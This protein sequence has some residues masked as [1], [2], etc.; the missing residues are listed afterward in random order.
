MHRYYQGKGYNW[1]SRNLP[2][3][4]PTFSSKVFFGVPDNMKTLRAAT[5]T[6]TAVAPV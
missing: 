6:T 2:H 5:T 4:S 1:E 3:V